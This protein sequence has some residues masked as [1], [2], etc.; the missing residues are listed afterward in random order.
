MI[1]VISPIKNKNNPPLKFEFFNKYN[2]HK[3]NIVYVKLIFFININFI[4]N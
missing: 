3:R 1:I 4:N 2:K